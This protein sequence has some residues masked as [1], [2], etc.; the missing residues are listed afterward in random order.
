MDEIPQDGWST[1]P[2]LA[3]VVPAEGRPGWRDA[4]AWCVLLEAWGFPADHLPAGAPVPLEVT[5]LIAP[6]GVE[7]EARP[8]GPGATVLAV[9]GGG[10]V[11]E[12]PPRRGNVVRFEA[13]ADDLEAGGTE[14]FADAAERALERAA[15]LGL[16]GLSR[17]PDGVASAL[18]VDGDV[19]HPSGVDPECSR[20]VVPALETAS[21]AGF[22]AYGIFVA[23][24]NVDHEPASFPPAAPGYYNHSYTHPYSHWDPRPWEDLEDREIADEL[25]RCSL[26]FRRRLDRGDDA[27][28]RLPHFQLEASGRTYRVLDD[29]GY[30]AESSVGANVAITGG[31]PFHPARRPWSDRGDDAAHARSHP[32]TAERHALLQLPLSTDPTDPAFPHGCCSYNTL[33]EGVRNRT[34]GP[35]AYERVLD[36]VLDTG[37]RRRGLVHVFIDPP[38]AG[39]GRLPGDAVHYA[40]AVERWMRGAVHRPDVATLTTAEL[41]RWWHA[42][43][44]AVPTLR[45]RVRDERLIVELGDA[46]PRTTI[47]VL[48]PRAVGGGWRRVPAPEIAA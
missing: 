20:Y 32:D 26:A 48:A 4:A 39:Y 3:V 41:A 37:V 42:R 30:R 2:R 25:R 24:A 6:E 22:D 40:D 5:T 36:R 23:G 17:W 35:G 11:S 9:G 31:L 10:R 21:R 7:E 19:D 43:E 27:M 29:L 46:P 16:V 12:R 18:V 14:R 33:G 38:D 44:A 28:F 34:A 1:P 45:T 47:T 8:P 13:S 15:P